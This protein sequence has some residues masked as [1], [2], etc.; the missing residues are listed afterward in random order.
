MW[1]KHRT[2]VI[3]PVGQ[4]ALDNETI[5]ELIAEAESFTFRTQLVKDDNIVG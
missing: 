1:L 5:K 3:G 4:D 2:L